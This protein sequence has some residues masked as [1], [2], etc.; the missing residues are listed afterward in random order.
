MTLIRPLWI[1]V[2]TAAASAASIGSPADAVKQYCI[3]C[4]N[5]RLKTGGLVLAGLDPAHAETKRGDL[6]EG[7]P[8]TAH[9]CHATAGAA[10]P[11]DATRQS[12]ISGLAGSTG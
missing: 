2:V 5:E 11:D 9:E 10:Q 6:G 3:G 8:K 1:F 4:H 12:L 7:H